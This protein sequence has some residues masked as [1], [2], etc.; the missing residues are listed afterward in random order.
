ML[1]R[2]VLCRDRWK[3]REHSRSSFQPPSTFLHGI[4]V[5]LRQ[6]VT[7][8]QRRYL[9]GFSLQHLYLLDAEVNYAFSLQRQTQWGYG[10]ELVLLPQELQ[11]LSLADMEGTAAAFWLLITASTHWTVRKTMKYLQMCIFVCKKN[12]KYK[13]SHLIP[14]SPTEAILHVINHDK[15]I[16]LQ[17]KKKVCPWCTQ[18]LLS[19]LQDEI[20]S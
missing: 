4:P 18:S 7:L 2:A 15:G 14:F 10:W 12:P 8:L 9:S 13:H 20:W 5:T 19:A 3:T 1:H 16:A 11:E 17:E 6:T